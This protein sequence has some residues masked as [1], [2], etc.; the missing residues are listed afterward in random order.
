M[1]LWLINF[2]PAG[3][4]FLAFSSELDLSRLLRYDPVAP[5]GGGYGA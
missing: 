5:A 1:D 3:K 4:I 2:G